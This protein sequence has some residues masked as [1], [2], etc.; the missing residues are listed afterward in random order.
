MLPILSTVLDVARPDGGFFLWAK[1]GMD[2]TAF[3]RRLFEQ[4]NV[5][6]VTGSYLSR[7]VDGVDPGAGWV[8]MA[9][10]APL[11]D[12]VAAAERI[13]DF[14]LRSQPAG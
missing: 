12:C 11:S 10:V 3:T 13:R 5:T 14:M 8:R 7:P 2:D 1:V 9:L 6:V 4:T